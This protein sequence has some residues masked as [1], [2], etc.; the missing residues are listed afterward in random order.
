MDRRLKNLG[1]CQVFIIVH[2]RH[3][4]IQKSISIWKVQNDK[5]SKDVLNNDSIRG[6]ITDNQTKNNPESTEFKGNHFVECYAILNN[7]CV[8]KAKINVIIK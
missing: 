4:N 2:I 5:T 8:A 3:Q 7:T 1:K 6:E